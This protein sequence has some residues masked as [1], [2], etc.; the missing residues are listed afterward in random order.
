MRRRSSTT[1]PADV[2]RELDALD[3]ALAG[4]PVPA[5]LGDLAAL[6]LTL[7]DDRPATG[8]AF[9]SRLDARAAAGFPV[10]AAGRRA[11]GRSRRTWAGAGIL[12]SGA[13]AA[14]L[15][16]SLTGGGTDG[17]T[18]DRPVAAQAPTLDAAQAPVDTAGSSALSATKRAPQIPAAP[19]ELSATVTALSAVP[20]TPAPPVGSV[21][22]AA[23]RSVERGAS[24]RLATTPR[25]LDDVVSGVVRVTD[26]AGGF[27]MSSSVDARPGTGGGAAFD[28]RIPSARLQGALAQLS[29]LAH[30]RSRTQS[31]FDVT[32]QVGSA[33]GRV[34]ALRAARRSVLRQLAAAST[35]AAAVPLRARLRSID[36]RLAQAKATR[37]DLRRRTTY[38]TVAVQ[39][40]TER[41][42]AAAGGGS[43][44]PGDALHDAGRVLGVVLGALLVGLAAL[45]PVA[46]LAAILIPLARAARRRRREH[47]LDGA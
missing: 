20:S 14:V 6:A 33:A 30:V 38:S 34:A 16:V 22:G 24:L 41:R 37:A 13:A 23:T 43:W 3:A 12:A 25:Q 36:S 40:V 44:T 47:A 32:A 42:Q 15:A 8:T 39:V 2:A 31:S 35:E 27:V 17:P 29:Q 46:L 10:Q 21:T 19:A 5:D 45:L 9:A 26:V 28:L 1:L 4:D 18:A 7:R 11:P